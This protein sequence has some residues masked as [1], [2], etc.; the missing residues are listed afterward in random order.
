MKLTNTFTQKYIDHVC[1]INPDHEV[2][3]DSKG[4]LKYVKIKNFLKNPEDLKEFLAHFPAIDR[5]KSIEENDEY[6][7]R[8]ALGSKAPGIQ[9]IIPQLYLIGIQEYLHILLNEINFCRYP[10]D[11]SIWDFYTNYLNKD[12]K[13]FASNTVPHTDPFSCACNIYLTDVENTGTQFFKYKGTKRDYYQPSHL[14]RDVLEFNKFESLNLYAS[15]EE[16]GSLNKKDLKDW[17]VF[18]GNN[19]FEEYHYIPA[20]YNSVS[21]YKGCFWHAIKYDAKNATKERY[22][23]V[24]TIK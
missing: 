16:I 8:Y 1:E 15:T 11:P 13:S 12:I 6:A 14:Q 17:E 3:S 20:E 22:S 24:A 23:L 2:I 9:Q 19:I 4:P 5:F 21:I 18:K 7:K 10:Y